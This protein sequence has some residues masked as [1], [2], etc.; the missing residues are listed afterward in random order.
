MKEVRDDSGAVHQQPGGD[1]K[2]NKRQPQCAA[3]RRASSLADSRHI[4]SL[5]ELEI[6]LV[7]LVF[8]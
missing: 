4:G 8:S 1:R 7:S 2:G 6:A 3:S 5:V